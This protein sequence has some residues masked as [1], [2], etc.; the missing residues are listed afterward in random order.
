MVVTAPFNRLRL[1]YLLPLRWGDGKSRVELGAYLEELRAICDEVIVVD[2]SP[3]PVFSANRAAWSDQV[4]HICPDWDLGEMPM[5]KVAGV[6]TGLRRAKNESVV[7]ADDD[8]RYDH[9]GLWRMADLLR[10]HDL[11]R[12]QNFFKPLPW[13]ARWDTARTLLNRA[14]GSDYPGTLGVMR[15]SMEI[16]KGYD[17]EMLFEN[18][19]L[20]RTV[21]AGGGSVVTVPSLYVRRVPPSTG[22]FLEQ[23]V[24]HA[25]EDFAMPLRMASWLA[26]PPV[27]IAAVASGRGKAVAQ[28]AAATVAVA[29][30][31]R[32]RAGGRRVF[33]FSSA[34]L[35][36]AWVFERGISAWLATAHRA[37]RGGLTYR[38][39]VIQSAANSKRVLREHYLP[40]GD[41]KPPTRRERRGFRRP[42]DPD[43]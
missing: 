42:I 34:L 27:S 5:G 43:F 25:Y 35:S 37:W 4:L 32:R 22:R 1:T 7:I 2:G 18:L 29:E 23:R 11:V 28:A 9:E 14:F 36:P 12:P 40:L 17:G 38:D 19:E 10:R 15:P 8:V 21:E 41:N 30:I 6:L 24:R 13:H 16:L 26:V 20:I 33:P 39:E 3:P 31:G